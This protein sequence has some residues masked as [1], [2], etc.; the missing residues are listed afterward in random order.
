MAFYYKFYILLLLCVIAKTNK[1]YNVIA[2]AN[3]PYNVFARHACPA[4]KTGSNLIKAHCL[5][6]FA[7]KV[8]RN[9]NSYYGSQRRT[10]LKTSL[11]RRTN[12]RTSLRAAANTCFINNI[13][14]E[15]ILSWNGYH[16][17]CEIASAHY[18]INIYTFLF[19]SQR[20]KIN[21]FHLL[22]L[23]LITYQGSQ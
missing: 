6:C 21:C 4:N 22:Q 11:Q 20:R 18:L 17:V 19:A 2:Q 14:G 23:I 12:F 7:M 10:S 1:P 9:S 3:K 15:A 13:C 5:D 16:F 8:S